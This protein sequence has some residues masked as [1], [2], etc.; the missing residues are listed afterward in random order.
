[1]IFYGQIL[2]WYYKIYKYLKINYFTKLELRFLL[3]RR[4]LPPL[5]LLLLLLL[6]LITVTPLVLVSSVMVEVQVPSVQVLVFVMVVP[7]PKYN[8]FLIIYFVIP[9]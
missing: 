5:L 9:V 2:Q 8:L 1:M 7:V 6:L 3:R 4:P